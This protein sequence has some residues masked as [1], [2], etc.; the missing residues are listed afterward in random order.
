[1]FWD[2]LSKVRERDT[3]CSSTNAANSC[4]LRSTTL[5][6]AAVPVTAVADA[7]RTATARSGSA[8]ADTVVP[9]P[10]P[11]MRPIHRN[12]KKCCSALS[13][14]PGA[15]DGG[16]RAG[17]GRVPAVIGEASNVNND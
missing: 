2:T 17:A 11:V 12:T 1:N 10:P 4:P 6:A 7:A 5:L 8:A 3:E 15:D 16:V 9:P 13:P 14:R